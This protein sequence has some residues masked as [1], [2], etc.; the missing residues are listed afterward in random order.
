MSS[1]IVQLTFCHDDASL[2]TLRNEMMFCRKERRQDFEFIF[3]Y[4]KIWVRSTKK[5]EN[6][7]YF[8]VHNQFSAS[9]HQNI[10][11]LR[12]FFSGKMKIKG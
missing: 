1:K 5:V 2:C 7:T 3:A 8:H 9:N 10:R 4:F 11:G 6:V 12:P